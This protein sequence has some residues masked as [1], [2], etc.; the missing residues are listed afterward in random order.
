M[1]VAPE[2]RM[3]SAVITNAAAGV[4]LTAWAL[5]YAVTT[6]IFINSSR[7]RAVISCASAVAGDAANKSEAT[8]SGTRLP[9]RVRAVVGVMGVGS[10]SSAVAPPVGNRK[11]I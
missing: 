4:S 10:R 3:S 7:L 9:R 5:R 8:S 2:R 6:S 1:V 11:S